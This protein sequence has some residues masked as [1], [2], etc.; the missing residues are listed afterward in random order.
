MSLQK[1]WPPAD[2]E[3]A[4]SCIF[5]EAETAPDSV[6]LAVHRPMILLRK[7]YQSDEEAIP[8]TEIQILE[9]F[10]RENPSSGTVVMPIIGERQF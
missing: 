6:F 4:G 1:F 3:H 8:Q 9:E 5:T 2:Q 7:T 10:I